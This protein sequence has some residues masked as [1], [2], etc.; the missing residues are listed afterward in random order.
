MDVIFHRNCMDGAFSAHSMY[1][2][3]KT[4]SKEGWDQFVNHLK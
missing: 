3:C 2:F 4:L 1:M